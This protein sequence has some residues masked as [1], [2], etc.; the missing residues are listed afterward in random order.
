MPMCKPRWPMALLAGLFVAGC[1]A[2]T[3]DQ[4]G[5]P[6]GQAP[7]TQVEVVT[8]ERQS[9]TLWTELPGRTS[10]YRV[11]AV[12][13]Q[14]D[15]ILRERTFEQGATVE[16]GQVLYRID[17][18]RYRA[19]V[20]QAEAELARARAAVTSVQLRERRF[21]DLLK[22]NNV[23]EQEYDDVKA[24]LDQR[25]AAVRAAE[26]ALE[27]ARLNL[28]YASVEAP[29]SGRIGPT[30][31]TTGMLATANQEQPLVRITQLDPIYVDIQRSVT[32]LQR[33]RR[34]VRTGMMADAGPDTVRVRLMMADGTEYPHPGTLQ[35][36]DVTVNENTGSVTLRAI[37]PNPD[38]DLL[39]GT[40]VRTRVLEGVRENAILA[41]QQGITHDQQG[42]AVA[43]IVNGN[44]IVERRTLELERA[45]GD[46]WLVADGLRAGDRLIVAGLLKIQPGD[47]VKAV[48]ADLEARPRASNG[49]TAPAG[50]REAQDGESDG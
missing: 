5:Q 31:L 26:A 11:A 50:G 33:L 35:L 41:P 40:F 45:I 46:R 1:D 42:R 44:E 23:S 15:G 38:Q 12:R 28:D 48:P 32:D 10:A 3:A 6:G 43:L 37:F 14:V 13:P 16:A 9:V 18:R 17:P 39:P 30:L 19:A 7:P 34:Q 36:T 27:T 8:L 21:A 22:K 2:E 24:E 20:N 4:S 49:E 29:I 47:E 25:L